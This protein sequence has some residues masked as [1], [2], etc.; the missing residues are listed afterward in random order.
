M[1]DITYVRTAEGW[2]YL[3]VVLDL[4]SRQVIGGSMQPQ[5]GRTLVL[6]AVLMA[7]WQWS[8]AETVILHSDRGT[9]D[10]TQEFQEFLTTHGLVSSMS[11]IGNCY[12][13]CGGGKFLW[14]TEV[15]RRRYATRAEARADVFDHIKRF[16]TR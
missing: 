5:L 16:Y 1:T 10:T 12:D 2:L 15:N 13:H 7:V 4:F 6:Q 14:I 3:A 8:T 11:G 9:Q